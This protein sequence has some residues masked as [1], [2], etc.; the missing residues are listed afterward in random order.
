MKVRSLKQALHWLFLVVGILALI[1]LVVSANTYFGFAKEGY[2]LRLD[3]ESASLAN[4]D[5]AFWLGLT[6][7]ITNPG[8]LDI[9]LQTATLSI[10]QVIYQF[11]PYVPQGLPQNEYPVSPLPKGETTTVLMWFNIG[12]T[13]HD[14][15][16]MGGQADVH[17]DMEIFIPKRNCT[18]S[19]V[20]EDVVV[21]P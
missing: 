10:Q 8:K 1:L 18:T 7:E 14:N 2:G 5:T 19:L 15:I 9:D 13:M 21:I 20:F 11:P 6:F 12:K 4:P 3:L 17:L 16:D